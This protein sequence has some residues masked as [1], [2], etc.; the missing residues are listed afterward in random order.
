M[1]YWSRAFAELK[2]AGNNDYKVWL[3]GAS[4]YLF[5]MGGVKFAVDLQIRRAADLEAVRDRLLEDVASLEFVLITHQH[6]DH[7]CAPLIRLARHLPTLWYLPSQ[8]PKKFID[9]TELPPD[10]FV[11]L[12]DGDGFEVRGL[13]VSAFNSPHVRPN[14][15]SFMPELGYRLC[16]NGKSVILPTDVRDYNYRDFPDITGADLCFSHL[17]AGDNAIDEL[18]YMPRLE[19]FVDFSLRFEAKKYFICHLYEI[20]RKEKF[21]WHKGHAAIA[22]RLFKKKAA[23]LTIEIPALGRAYELF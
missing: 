9:S 11:L 14:S 17:W 19:D 22:E 3:V 18:E 8:M 5:A 10:R 6:D 12:E 21:M 1:K 20:G 4:S 15:N 13:S 23:D 7:F 16:A 2:A